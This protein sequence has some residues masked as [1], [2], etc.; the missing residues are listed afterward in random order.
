MIYEPHE[1]SNWPW[2]NVSVVVRS[3]LEPTTLTNAVTRM[4]RERDPNVA[5]FLVK[6]MDKV[7][8]ESVA[9]TR[10][11]ARLL[12][13]FGAL[14]LLLAAAGVYCVMSHLVSQRTHEIGVRM[15]LGAERGE[16]VRMVLAR[17]LRNALVGAAL[18]LGLTFMASAGLRAFVIGI[19]VI[20]VWTYLQAVAGIIAVAVVASCLPAFR[21][22]RVDPLI[23]LRDE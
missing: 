22:S 15:A 3:S 13:V 4:V 14:A 11:L 5:V 21:A 19:H 2:T 18:G 10:L 1:Q 6:T 17:G 7:V 12:T 8:A 20:D 23:A 9:G 16:V